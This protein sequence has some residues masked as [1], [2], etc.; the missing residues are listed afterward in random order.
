MVENLG[1]VLTS[2]NLGGYCGSRSGESE[3]VQ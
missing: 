3:K 1:D 2:L